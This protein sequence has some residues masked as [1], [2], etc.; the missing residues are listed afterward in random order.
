MTDTGFDTDPDALL[1]TSVYVVVSD[2]VSFTEVPLTAPTPLR[3]REVAPLT[4][5]CREEDCP[6]STVAGVA[7]SLLITGAPAEEPAAI[8][9]IVADA[10]FVES[11]LLVAVTVPVPVVAG[12]V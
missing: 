5:H 8:T 11:A 7:L 10:D 12:A 2:G 1:A 6:A 9:V 4:V 3:E